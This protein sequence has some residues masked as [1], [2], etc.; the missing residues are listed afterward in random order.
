[1]A[2]TKKG[3]DPLLAAAA[4]AAVGAGVALAGVTLNNPKNQKKIK[5]TLNELKVKGE[6]YVE[7]LQDESEK[8]KDQIETG[9]EDKK[10]EPKEDLKN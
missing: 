6:D 2:N 8:V 3:I 4:G 1:M 7:S 5:K 10:E 9:A